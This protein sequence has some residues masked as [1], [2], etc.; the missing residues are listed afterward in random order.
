M[1]RGLRVL[2]VALALALSPAMS[3]STTAS[4]RRP[5]P[6]GA[7]L[8]RVDLAALPG[9]GNDDHLGAFRVFL[10]SCRAIAGAQAALRPGLPPPDALVAVC[11]AALDAGV[12]TR[13]DARAFFLSRFDAWEIAPPTGAGFLTGYYEPEVAAALTRSDSFPT[14]V[15]ARPDDLV[16]FPQGHTPAP[17]DPALSAA[18]RRVDGALE[19]YPTR[20]EI[21]AGGLGEKARPIAFLADP[22]EAFM[23]HVQGSARLSLPDGSTLRLV[24]DGRNGRPYVSVGRVLASEQGVD[25][26]ELVLEK[27][28]ARIRAMGLAPGEPGLALLHR[29]PSFIFFRLDASAPADAGPIG[30]QGVRLSPLRS[31]AVDRTLW[32]YGLPFWIEA[33]LPWSAATPEPFARLAIAQDTGSAILGPARADLFFGAGDEAGR[34]AGDIRHAGRFVVLWPKGDAP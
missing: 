32:P 10:T 15:L 33:D 6:G 22:V 13:A 34:R 27:L 3:A 26:E 20:G 21:E 12:S 19:P 11:R 4:E 18:R 8:T 9:F 25:P 14:P 29:N 16:T 2:A 28:K 5:G 1:R 30:A 24:Y 17:L 7:G 31:I 23:I